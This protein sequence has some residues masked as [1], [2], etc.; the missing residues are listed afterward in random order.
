MNRR[1]QEIQFKKQK[2]IQIHFEQE[3]TEGTE[4]I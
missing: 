1:G 4:G 3:G 2:Q